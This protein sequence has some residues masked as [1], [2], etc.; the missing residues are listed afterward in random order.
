MLHQCINVR[1]CFGWICS[2]CGSAAGQKG[3]EDMLRSFPDE[4]RV[5]ED[6]KG[7][8]SVQVLAPLKPQAKRKSSVLT[9]AA[10]QTH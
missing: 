4:F 1:S 3:L 6:S 10:V 2:T 5:Y 7:Q 9:S 8:L